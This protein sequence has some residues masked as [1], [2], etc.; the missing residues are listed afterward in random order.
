MSPDKQKAHEKTNARDQGKEHEKRATHESGAHESGAQKSGSESRSKDQAKSNRETKRSESK[1]S[2]GQ[3]A[4]TTDHEVIRRWI[5]ARGGHPATVKATAAGAAGGKKDPGLLRVDFPGRGG[6]N[7]LDEISW[8]EFF[9][10][11]EEKKLA[12]LYQEETRTGRESR[13]SKFIARGNEEGKGQSK[14]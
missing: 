10:K 3:S 12:F 7:R 14:K 13:F 9:D 11:F 1:L 5:E 8:E 2:A 4:T 6:E